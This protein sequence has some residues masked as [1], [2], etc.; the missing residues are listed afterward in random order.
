M[1]TTAELLAD[2]RAAY[3]RLATGAAVVTVRD[4]NGEL[5]T[6]HPTTAKVLAAYIAE[7]ERLT[8]GK[9]PVLSILFRTTKGL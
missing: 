5:V 8:A 1:T 6:Y 2:A 3:H 4:Q 7:L 9:R